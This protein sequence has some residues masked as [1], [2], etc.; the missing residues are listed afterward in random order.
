MLTLSG[1]LKKIYNL[2]RFIVLFS[3]IFRV[4]VVLKNVMKYGSKIR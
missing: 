4:M 2:L 1:N 3:I